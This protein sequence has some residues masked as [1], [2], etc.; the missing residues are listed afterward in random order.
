VALAVLAMPA[1]R[2]L[3]ADDGK[4][5]DWRGQWLRYIGPGVVGQASHDQ[6]RPGGFGQQAPLTPEY[7]AVLKDSLADQAKGGLGNFPTARCF[8]AGMPHMM[9]AFGPQEYVITPATTYILVNWDDHNRRIFTDGRDW[10][11]TLE[12]TYA[13]YSIGRWID[14]DGEVETRGPFMGPRAYDAAGLPLAFDNQSI[15]RER[16]HLDRAN[17][18]ILHN[19]MTVIDHALTRPWT[20]DKKYLRN[21]DPRPS[22]P[23]YYC[24]ENNAQVSIGSENYFLSSDGRL[25]P[26]RKGQPPPD[27]GYFTRPK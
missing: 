12:P 19:E 22:W 14:E 8:P 9:M 27:L 1:G 6:T 11:R 26:T 18:D 16:I 4:Y 10:P 15:F 23:E 17:P 24:G 5:P 21:P 20:V 13:G 7:Q 2:A 25:M 3:A